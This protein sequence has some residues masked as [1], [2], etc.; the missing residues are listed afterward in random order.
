MKRLAL[1]EI[2]LTAVDAAAGAIEEARESEGAGCV[3]ASKAGK[4]AQLLA[5][6]GGAA[7]KGE[8]M[9]AAGGLEAGGAD[10]TDAAAAAAGAS[11]RLAEAGGAPLL[12]AATPPPKASSKLANPLSEA[13]LEGFE[14]AVVEVGGLAKGSPLPKSPKKLLPST[15]AAVV[16][17]KII[18]ICK[19][20]T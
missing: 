2:P 16:N 17:G 14:T 8:A 11:K 5:S 12:P 19:H 15:E 7:S 1:A 4:E 18:S 6:S 9:A 3:G 20:F 10:V 13:G